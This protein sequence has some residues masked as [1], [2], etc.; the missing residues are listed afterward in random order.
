MT[1][2]GAIDCDIHPG[3]PDIKALLPYMNDYWRDRS[4]R[5]AWT[6]STW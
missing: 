1:V 3:V 6:V 4:S 2:V 5:A